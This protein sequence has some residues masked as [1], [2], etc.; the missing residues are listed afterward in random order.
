MASAAVEDHR[1]R[2]EIP[3]RRRRG[4]W[5]GG[6]RVQVEFPEENGEKGNMEKVYLRKLGSRSDLRVWALCTAVGEGG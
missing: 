1:R 5:D 6:E 4:V 2:L 3:R